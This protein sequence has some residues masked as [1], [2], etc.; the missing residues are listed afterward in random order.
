[1]L[2]I[3]GFGELLID[4]TPAGK[5]GAGNELFECNPGGSV[6]NFCVAAR[7]QG[8][9]AAFMGQVGADMFG[10][11][12]EKTMQSYDVDTRS[13]VS[14]DEFMT[15]LAFVHLFENGDRDFSFYRKNGADANIKPEA[16][17][18]EVLDETRALH[19]ASLTLVNE[20]CTHTTKEVVSYAKS[21]GKL[22][23]YDPNWRPSLWDSAE[24][25]KKGMLEGFKYADIAKVSEEELE[26]V[27]GISDQ[28]AA[29]HTLL[30]MGVGLVVVTMG[31]KGSKFFSARDTGYAD[32]FV[33]SAVDATGAGDTCF[34]TF[35]AEWLL[36]GADIQSVNK[37]DV[38]CWL[39]RANAAAA[40]SVTRRGGMPSVPSREEVDNLLNA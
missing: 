38:E 36:R 30:D 20:T 14:T 29:S 17:R 15:T 11:L 26:Y 4:F 10:R 3:V 24:D 19:F 39:K 23:T 8:C 7:K 6:A 32:P 22:I 37:S 12:L 35:V 13:L 1:M 9:Q 31:E 33:V 2:D 34:G 5:S 16:I 18:F 40:I 21:R 25:C 27:T 28:K